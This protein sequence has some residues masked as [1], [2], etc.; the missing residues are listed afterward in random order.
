MEDCIESSAAVP[1]NCRTG[2]PS[3][4]QIWSYAQRPCLISESVSVLKPC[5]EVEALFTVIKMDSVMIKMQNARQ[6]GLPPEI[7]AATYTKYLFSFS[8][9]LMVIFKNILYIK[10]EIEAHGRIFTSF[11]ALPDDLSLMLAW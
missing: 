3:C 4:F 6:T 2:W 9:N 10:Q 7:R 11:T 8:S 5:T 1:H